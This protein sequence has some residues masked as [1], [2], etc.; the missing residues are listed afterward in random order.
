MMVSR[1]D[2]LF[3]ITIPQEARTT[4]RVGE[5]YV[6]LPGKDGRFLLLPVSEVNGILARTAGMWQERDDVPT[7]GVEYV[8]RL[9]TGSRLADL[10]ITANGG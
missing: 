1:V 2:E 7:D 3:R 10:E 5:E 9:R 6:V 8:N 4:V